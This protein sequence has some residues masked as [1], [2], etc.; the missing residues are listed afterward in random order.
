LAACFCWG[1]ENNCTRKISSKSTAQIVTLKVFFPGW[2][3]W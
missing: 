1:L 3:L 2:D